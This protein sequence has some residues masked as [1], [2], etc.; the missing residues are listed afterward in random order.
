MAYVKAPRPRYRASG[1]RWPD[2]VVGKTLTWS[3]GFCRSSACALAA[4]RRRWTTLRPKPASIGGGGGGGGTQKPGGGPGWRRAHR[5]PPAVGSST[6]AHAE[7]LTA[8]GFGLQRRTR[9]A[10]APAAAGMRSCGGRAAG[11]GR[12]DGREHEP[13]APL[14]AHYLFQARQG[15]QADLAPLLLGA[16]GSIC[17][18]CHPRGP[19]HH[20]PSD[21]FTA[22]RPPTPGTPRVP[23]GPP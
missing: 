20:P 7:P 8:L 2:A 10:A 4:P 11:V 9:P 3:R 14:G 1:V 18:L 17:R 15:G 19:E 21:S 16:S 6:H 22:C 5:A 23:H 13:A 12:H